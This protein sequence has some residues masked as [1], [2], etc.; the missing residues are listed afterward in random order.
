M[1]TWQPWA[2]GTQTPKQTRSCA[3][4]TAPLHQYRLVGRSTSE[5]FA[6]GFVRRPSNAGSF[7]TIPR[8]CVLLSMIALPSLSRATVTASTLALVPLLTRGQ[9]TEV[10]WSPSNSFDSTRRCMT[11]TNKTVRG[12]HAGDATSGK[13]RDDDRRIQT[14]SSTQGHT[15]GR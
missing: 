6:S 3:A 2:G 13:G 4:R 14:Y 15:T 10:M 5:C 1:R 12:G 11:A 8:Q 9:H 7:A